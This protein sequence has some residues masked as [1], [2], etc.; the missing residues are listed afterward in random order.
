MAKRAMPKDQTLN[1]LAEFFKVF[2]DRS[3]VKIIHALFASERCVHDL[4]ARLGMQQ[5]TVS[6]QLRVLKQAGLV[7][8]RRDGKLAIY[9]LADEH[10]KK[11]FDQAMAHVTEG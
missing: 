3:R 4:A 1:D 10:I 9:A 6:H 7:S 2:G 8:Y 11:I 5:S